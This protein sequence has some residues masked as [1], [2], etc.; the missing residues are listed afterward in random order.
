MRVFRFYYMLP[1]PKGLIALTLGQLSCSDDPA[2]AGGFGCGSIVAPD[3]SVVQVYTFVSDMLEN[4]A[5]SYGNQVGWLILTIGVL[6]ILT[7]IG[8][9]FISHLKR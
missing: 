6:K 8:F 5:E 1:T 9:R 4:S 2:L 7:A 3:G